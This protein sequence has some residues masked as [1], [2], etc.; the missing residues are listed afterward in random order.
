MLLLLNTQEGGGVQDGTEL[1]TEKLSLSSIV[2][3][4][5]GAQW[6]FIEFCSIVFYYSLFYFHASIHVLLLIQSW[7]TGGNSL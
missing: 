2:V 3:C 1:P 4:P 7:A 5:S 6:Q